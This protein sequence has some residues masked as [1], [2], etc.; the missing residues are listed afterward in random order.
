MTL[1]TKFY[2]YFDLVPEIIGSDTQNR[3]VSVELGI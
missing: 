1:C 2:D 3:G